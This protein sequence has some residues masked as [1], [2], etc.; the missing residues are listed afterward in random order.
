MVQR[1][2]MQSPISFGL[3]QE[4]AD[5]IVYKDLLLAFMCGDGKRLRMVQ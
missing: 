4:L 3:L 2:E 1:M 5:F